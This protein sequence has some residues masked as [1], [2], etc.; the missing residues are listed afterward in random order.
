MDVKT[1]RY[2]YAKTA[3]TSCECCSAFHSL[4]FASAREEAA[5]SRCCRSC[6]SKDIVKMSLLVKRAYVKQGGVTKRARYGP[7]NLKMVLNP[8]A[9]KVQTSDASAGAGYVRTGG[10]YGRYAPVT[11]GAVEMKF[12]DTTKANTTVAAA[13]TVLSPSLNLIP[14]GTTESNRIGR[15]CVVRGVH[16]YATITLPAPTVGTASSYA[17]WVR[18]VI[19]KD[20]QCNGAAAVVTDIFENGDLNSFHNL[21]NSGR[22]KTLHDELYKIESKSGTNAVASQDF[23]QCEFHKN[24]KLPLEF[25]NTTGAITEIKS[26]NILVLAF[27]LNGLAT[28]GYRARV[29]Y[30]DS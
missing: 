1:R 19:V 21:A 22:F 8:A 12:F 2:F 28:V 7:G 16:M 5:V 3:I 18:L 10:Y 24:M 29:R 27:T 11:Q 4:H 26:N 30:S 17:D 23:H 6:G 14:Q 15:K 13:G 20:K 9:Q 25:D